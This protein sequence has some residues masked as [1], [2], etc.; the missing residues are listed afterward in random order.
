LFV[1]YWGLTLGLVAMIFSG[2]IPAGNHPVQVAAAGAI[3]AVL[4]LIVGLA[5][6]K[7]SSSWRTAQRSAGG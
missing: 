1:F 5:Q 3:G 4:G 6:V 7:L 2:F